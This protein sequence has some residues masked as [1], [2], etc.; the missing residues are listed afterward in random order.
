MRLFYFL[1]FFLSYSNSA[2]ITT[3]SGSCSQCLM[4]GYNYCSDNSKCV[5]NRPTTCF[6]IIDKPMQC[7]S[8]V[9][10][11]ITISDI[12]VFSQKEAVYLLP[13]DTLCVLP[14]IYTLSDFEQ[15]AYFM[16]YLDSTTIRYNIST[17]ATPTLY[18]QLSPYYPGWRQTINS[19]LTTSY[20]LA[21]NYG[22]SA[23]QFRVIYSGA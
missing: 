8:M 6:T 13:P 20:V 7:A 15:D 16:V 12:D 18:S 17:T 5:D 21:Q 19:D 2:E 4:A 3:Y 9:C 1:A 23:V 14:M 10:T 11:P 22:T